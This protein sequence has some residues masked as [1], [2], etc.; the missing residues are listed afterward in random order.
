MLYEIKIVISLND[1]GEPSI[2][3]SVSSSLVAWPTKLALPYTKSKMALS[4]VY[5]T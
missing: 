5:N 1:A 3:S 4:G 2:F